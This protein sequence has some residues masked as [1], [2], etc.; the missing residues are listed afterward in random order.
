MSE[1]NIHIDPE[2]SIKEIFTKITMQSLF[3]HD[4][5][6]CYQYYDHL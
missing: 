4:K 6:K 5:R 2:K 3:E 1:S